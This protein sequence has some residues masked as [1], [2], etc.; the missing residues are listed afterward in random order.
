MPKVD[1]ADHEHKKHH[2]K[3]RDLSTKVAP[4]PQFTPRQTL[5]KEFVDWMHSAQFGD[6]E[7]CKMLE[8]VLA[9]SFFYEQ[10]LSALLMTCSGLSDGLAFD[11]LYKYSQTNIVI[12]AEK[13]GIFLD[14]LKRLR[15]L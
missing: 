12:D 5:I 2:H 8:A 13:K 7:L 1:P 3:H 11:F 14:F 15:L 6:C 9:G 10:M 4:P